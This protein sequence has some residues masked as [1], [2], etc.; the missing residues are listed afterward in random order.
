MLEVG[1]YEGLGCSEE[2][3]RRTESQVQSEKSL[4]KFKQGGVGSQRAAGSYLSAF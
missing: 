3:V 2:A 1:K 4:E